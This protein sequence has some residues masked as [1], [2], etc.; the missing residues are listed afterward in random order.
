MMKRLSA[1]VLLALAAAVGVASA[2]D[3][4]GSA[5]LRMPWAD[6]VKA[7]EAK[8]IVVIDVR[9]DEAFDAGHIPGAMSVPLPDVEKRAAELKKL[10]KPLAIYCA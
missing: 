3:D 6:F 8:T 9:G 2:Q 7:Y 4:L 1:A 5:R 10:K